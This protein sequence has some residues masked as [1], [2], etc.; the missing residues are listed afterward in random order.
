M[1]IS[2]ASVTV[3]VAI[4]VVSWWVWRTLKWAWF[5]PKMLESYLRRQGL[6]G[7]PYTPLVGDLNKSFS[8]LKEARSKPIKLTDDIQPRVVP[9]PLQMRKT[10]GRTFFTWFGHIP[11]ITI[12]DPEQIKE[13]FNNVYD[14]PKTHAFP[15]FRLIAAGLVSYDGEKW[16]KHRRIINPAFHLEKIKIMVPAFHQSCCEVVGEWDKL[17]SEK[18]SS[19]EVD[20]WPWLVSLTAD[21]HKLFAKLSSLDICNEKPQLPWVNARRVE[22]DS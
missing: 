10:H 15:L 22:I 7:T 14:F 12:M 13:V 6:S 3:S 2:L 18:G 4:A 16:A 19:C 21:V 20:V 1:E 17:V 9:Y 8:M 11:T 5:K